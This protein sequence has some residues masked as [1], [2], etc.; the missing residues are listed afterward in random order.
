[1]VTRPSRR[2]FRFVGQSYY[3]S[4]RKHTKVAILS[5]SSLKMFRARLHSLSSFSTVSVHN[6]PTRVVFSS[7]LRYSDKYKKKTVLVYLY[8][9]TIYIHRK[10]TRR[11][12]ELIMVGRTRE[13][14]KKIIHGD[15]YNYR[16]I[17]NAR[18]LELSKIKTIEILFLK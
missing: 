1:M 17:Y 18:E 7:T 13:V 3:I 4:V 5:S 15:G 11:V 6:S 16:Y 12:I 14:E 10:K 2:H 8:R 9:D